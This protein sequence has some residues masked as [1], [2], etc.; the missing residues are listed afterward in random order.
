MHC[1]VWPYDLNLCMALDMHKDAHSNLFGFSKENRKTATQAEKRLWFHL[2]N[3][4]LHGF[5]FRRQHPIGAFVADFYCHEG[6]LVIEVDGG[7][8]DHISQH[9]YDEGRSYELEA[10]GIQVIRFT[11]DEIISDINTV[12]CT[13]KAHLLQRSLG[14]PE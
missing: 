2:R 12:L 9:R 3:R 6:K 5:K 14:L 13:I 11:N 1:A 4:K 10:L 7:Y 8:H